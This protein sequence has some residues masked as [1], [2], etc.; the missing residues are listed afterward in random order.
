MGSKLE[1]IEEKIKIEEKKKEVAIIEREMKNPNFWTDREKSA[2]ESKK[3][4]NLKS[5]IEEI[6]NLKLLESLGSKEEFNNALKIFEL[7]VNLSGKY[8]FGGAYLSI[9]S[10]QGGVEAMDWAEMLLRMYIRFCESKNWKYSLLNETKGEEAGIKSASLEISAPYAYG[11]LKKESG[12]HRLVRQ[13]PFNADNLRQTSFALVE[14]IPIIDSNSEIRIEDKD[15]EIQF[16]RSSGAG[17]QNV[18]KVS[19]AVRITHIPT[20]IVVVSQSERN[21]SKNR[22]IALKILKGRL[23]EI[24]ERETIDKIESIKG[25]YKPATWSHQI[26]NYVLHPYKQVKDLRTGIEST[27]PNTVLDGDLD[28]FLEAQIFL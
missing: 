17:G 24:M 18:N 1:K 15:I 19:T 25:N 8:D 9:H 20:N 3:L 5:E 21:Q 2:R 10:G 4:S 23:A 28:M 16:F 6:D 13:S 14:V 26:R 27:N 22:D 12:A 7:K 11:Y